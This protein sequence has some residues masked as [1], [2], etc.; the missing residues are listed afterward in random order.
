ELERVT[1]LTIVRKSNPLHETT[2]GLGL[3]AIV[4]IEFL[5]VHWRNVGGEVALMIETEH[6]GVS[7]VLALQLKLRMRFREIR[8]RRGVTLRRSRQL[9]DDLLRRVRM[10]MKSVTWNRRSFLRRRG[11]RGEII[12]ADSAFRT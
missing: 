11:H 2:I 8:E 10:S 1:R 7:R 5:S 4:A 9:E 3:M 12:V 6:V